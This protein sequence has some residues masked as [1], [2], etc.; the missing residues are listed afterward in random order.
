VVTDLGSAHPTWFD[1]RVER[2][3]VP[4]EP[5]QKL[6]LRRGM[7]PENVRLLGLPTRPAFWGDLGS[8]AVAAGVAA[9]KV[10]ARRRLGL[11]TDVPTA[12]LV[13]GGDGFGRLRDIA[14][15][16]AGQLADDLPKSQVVVVAGNNKKLQVQLQELPWPAA[17]KVSVVI[18]GFV[19]NMD[20]W[21][22]AADVL[23]TKAGPG[24]IAE[25]CTKGLPLVLSS[26]LPGQEKGNVA[27][28]TE[29]GFGV[30]QKRPRRIAA[31]VSEWLRDPARLAAMGGKARREGRPTATLD[32][33][34]D[35]ADG[36]LQLA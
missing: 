32:I 10:A 24:T 34:K 21:M 31:T 12:L 19:A 36:V 33:A 13:G 5:L 15:A 27:L 22:A 30:Y 20:E 6:A 14:V 7:A 9:D 35:I 1:K 11:A 16:V 26:Y 2:V 25:A 3:Y 23:V 18:K 29:G 17:D 8:S 28:V 4:S